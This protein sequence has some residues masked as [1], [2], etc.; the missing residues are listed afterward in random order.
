MPADR[1]A[2]TAVLSSTL[3]VVQKVVQLTGTLVSMPL[4]LHALGPEGFGIWGAAASLAWL[5]STVDFGL[6]NVL[7]TAIAGAV[8]R[9]DMAEARSHLAAGLVLA[10]ALAASLLGA[11]AAVVPG[12]F[13]PAEAP[14]YLIAVAG[15][16]LNIPGS[17]AAGA[18][19]GLQKTHMVWGCDAAQ[20]VLTVAGLFALSLTTSD[21]RLF[22]A[23]TFGG[24]VVANLASLIGLFLCHPQLRPDGRW[25]RWEELGR[26]LRR[27]LPYFLL[28]LA[29]TLTIYVDN[30]LTLSLLGSEAAGRMAIVQRA[31]ITALGLLW[32]V[33]QP[34][35]PA[36]TDAAV[37]GDHRWI[38]IH[39]VRA[40]LVVTACAVGGSALLI[41]LGP[42]LLEVWLHG[43]L[44]LSP[45]VLWAMAAWI[46][47]LAVGRVPDVLLNA[48]GV[49]WFQVAVA[50][51]FSV[52][53]FSLK[54]VLAPDL[55]IAG[56]LVATAV[57]YGLTHLPA[58]VWWVRRW[59]RLSHL[60]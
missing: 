48:V 37:R 32:A 42:R 54:F 9:G 41:V 2:R 21:V 49:V 57:A 26:L 5:V 24:L 38:R 56:I 47:V 33:T 51:V 55:G 15:L 34:L 27:G 6:T 23:A 17:L 22:V 44:T 13:S 3:G 58:Y 45:P 36:F 43:G 8:A 19:S 60:P 28:G 12:V 35:W 14:A 11:A 50:L 10:L 16:A 31:G 59:L 20:T 30:V 7:V 1:R 25:P 18:W 39:L 52:L 4:V 40:S 29:Q 53:A 46:G